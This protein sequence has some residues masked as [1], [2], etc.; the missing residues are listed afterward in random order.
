LYIAVL[1]GGAMAEL[2]VVDDVRLPQ[3]CE[4]ENRAAGKT[5]N[6]ALLVSDDYLCCITTSTE[7]ALPVDDNLCFISVIR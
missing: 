3:N 6:L 4:N 1:P 5:C 2:M 7:L